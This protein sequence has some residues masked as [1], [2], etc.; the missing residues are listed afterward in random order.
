MLL[1]QFRKLASRYFV[2]DCLRK[3]I[4]LLRLAHT[5]GILNKDF[6]AIIIDI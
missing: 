1:T 3:Q 4:S 6:Y 2:K 5:L